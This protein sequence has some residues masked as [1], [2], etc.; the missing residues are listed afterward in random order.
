MMKALEHRAVPQLVSPHEWYGRLAV[1]RNQL[2]N[3][4]NLIFLPDKS[5]T[6]HFQ[7]HTMACHY[8]PVHGKYVPALCMR[9]LCVS[10]HVLC[11]CL[12]TKVIIFYGMSVDDLRSVCM[13]G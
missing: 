12:V 6:L 11:N 4:E 13:R 9:V 8:S 5:K 7:S 2:E 10:V 3:A 1:C